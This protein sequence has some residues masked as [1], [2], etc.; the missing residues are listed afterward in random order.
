MISFL[1]GE[2]AEK[3]E[4]LAVLNVNGVGYELFISNATLSTLPE[5]GETTKLLSYMAVREDGVFL[6]GFSSTEEKD[7]FLKLITVSGIGPK[8]AISILSGLTI[9]DLINAIISGDTR[10]LCNIKGLG[11][12]TAERICLELKDK[13]SPLGVMTDDIMMGSISVV[14]E[15]IV[16][17][18]SDTLIALGINKN[19]AYRLAKSNYRDGDTAEDVIAKSLR[20]YKG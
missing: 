12:K 14:N 16:E 2:I 1:I 15:D 20:G 9:S 5:V 13:I 10:M 3:R 6:F 11:K 4:G 19:E 8:V 18:A 17:T 7:L